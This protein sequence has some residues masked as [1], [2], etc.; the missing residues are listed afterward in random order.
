MKLWTFLLFF[1]N[2]IKLFANDKKLLQK[3]HDTYSLVRI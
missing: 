3:K 2:Q 1:E